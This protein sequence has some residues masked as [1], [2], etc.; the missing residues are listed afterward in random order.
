MFGGIPVV[1]TAARSYHRLMD[2]QASG[3]LET[4]QTNGW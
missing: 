3:L 4:A 1:A 2:W